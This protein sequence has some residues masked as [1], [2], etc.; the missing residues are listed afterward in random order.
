MSI[1]Y[2]FLNEPLTENPAS[3]KS[4]DVFQIK[5]ITKKDNAVVSAGA[6]SGKTDVLAL[7]YA[8][9]LMTDENIRIKNI[10]AL[11]FTKEAASEIYDRIYKKLNAF[12]KFLDN[13]KYPKQVKLAKRALDE[14]ADAK[15][16][17]LDAYSG[18][19]VRIA[20]SRYGIRPDFTTGSSSCD[21]AVEDAALPFVLK[22]RTEECF[23]VYSMPGKIEDF[24]ANYF[25]APVLKCT[26]VA[27]RKNFFSDNFQIQKAQIIE[28]WNSFF[29]ENENSIKSQFEDL[30]LLLNES[31]E[32]NTFVSELKELVDKNDFLLDSLDE[33]NANSFSAI[34]QDFCSSINSICSINMNK[35][36]SKGSVKEIKEIIKKIRET[37]PIV[38]SVVNFI[39]NFSAQKRM[40]ELL[41]EFL[42][43]VNNTKRISGN[44]SF[45]DVGDLALRILIEQPDIRKQQ[46]NLIK[47]IMIDEF[48][49]N[50]KKNKELLF[51]ISENDGKELLVENKTETEFFIELEKNI[52]TEKL[53]FV[54]DEKQSIYKFRGADVSVFNELKKSLK[55]N[56]GCE[57]NVN[58]NMTNNYRS[59]VPLLYSFNLMFGNCNN[60]QPLNETEIPSLFYSEENGIANVKS[61]EA[62]YKH[63][64]LKKNE[65]PAS[66]SANNVPVH[67]C[68]LNTGENEDG[69]SFSDFV[70]YGKCLSKEETEAYFIARKI[71][72]LSKNDSNFNNYAILDNSRSGRFY[73]QRYLSIFNIPYTVD[74][75]TNVFSEGI[76]ND[77]Y[78]FLRFCVYPS[79]SNAF[80]AFLSSPFAGISMQG[81]QNILSSSVKK[82][83]NSE[84]LFSAFEENDSLFLS[85]S[86]MKKYL[87]AK[88]FYEELRD[89][90]LSQSLTKS[91]ELLWYETGY[92]FETILNRNLSLYSE[93][94]DL[95]YET[96]RQAENEGKSISWFVDQLGIAKKKEI[97]SYMNDESVE[98]E[99]KEISY[100]IEKPDAVKIMTIHQSKGLQFRHVFVIG[101]W[102]NPKAQT[103]GTFFFDEDGFDGKNATG[104]SLCALGEGG[105]Y[106]SVRQKEDSALRELAEQKRKIYVAITRAEED[107][108]LVGSLSRSKELKKF[109]DS[110]N[111]EKKYDGPLSLMHKLCRFYY[112]KELYADNDFSFESYCNEPVFNKN[113]APFDFIKINPVSTKVRADDKINLDELRQEKIKLFS[114]FY[115]K[116]PFEKDINFPL[117]FFD[118][119]QTP[120][121]LEKLLPKTTVKI[122]NAFKI[123]EEYSS[124][125]LILKPDVGDSEDNEEDSASSEFN[126]A[127]FGKLV[128]SYLESFVSTGN[129]LNAENFV[130]R[131]VAKKLS[132]NQKAKEILLKTVVS[133]CE[134]FEKS[135]LGKKVADAKNSNRLCKAE[136]KFKFLMDDTIF[137]GS[138]DLIFQDLDQK[139]FI[140]DYKTD[141]IA[142]PELYI[143]Q[144]SCYRKAASEIFHVDAKDIKT[145]LYYLR[146]DK[147]IDISAYT[148]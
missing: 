98:L 2:N 112:Q 60:N 32:K 139:L 55:D 93:Q 25:A 67:L 46:K 102:G 111:A 123:N 14:F 95:L 74:R 51:L 83:R 143:E 114:A 129:I 94:F 11:T 71:Y 8:F 130:D 7:R 87:A 38:V 24:A 138:M 47:K 84:I 39:K 82:T 92:Y 59:S 147:E 135:E 57:E 100:P 79:D 104:V 108:H 117:E 64:A 6:G 26:S 116:I 53:F 122:D 17:T 133:M 65:L 81:V 77:F 28:E 110:D 115:D 48:Q 27:T 44:L 144:L 9:L 36:G 35:G 146:Y 56:S 148:I 62:E 54:G 52:S 76:V 126:Y 12:V 33:K 85:D 86:D 125:D 21:R 140:V 141:R 40:F 120:S 29:D 23:N 124:V 66:V 41:D 31:D 131:I 105:N 58:L 50:N 132:E 10:L 78:C 142:K 5:A 134:A 91:L 121:G 43:E 73:L 96:A 68:L 3:S 34:A 4:P 70:N 136:N 128:H 89:D 118:K 63:N 75:Q 90:I 145:F 18:S 106:F 30:K 109:D 99:L 37:I 45:K 49:D 19:L 16:Q 42:E 20:A 22:H 107:V 119:T 137:T 72:E 15:I 113:G 101:I 103:I 61:Y 88:N 69:S 80:A 1:D 13:D 97:S 127:D